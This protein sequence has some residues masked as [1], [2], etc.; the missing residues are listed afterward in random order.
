MKIGVDLFYFCDYAVQQCSVLPVAPCAD[1]SVQRIWAF[2]E[3]S[4]PCNLD[5]AN[6][7]GD[8][9]CIFPCYIEPHWSAYG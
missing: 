8:E 2:C 3:S 4:H 9:F 1:A 5:L 6:G 7:S